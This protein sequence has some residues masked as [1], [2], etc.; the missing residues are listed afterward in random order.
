[1]AAPQ[2]ATAAPPARNEPLRSSGWGSRMA[3][4]T[5]VGSVRGTEVFVHWSVAVG[6]VLVFVVNA[7]AVDD[8]TL[9]SGEVTLAGLLAAISLYVFVLLHEFGHVEAHRCVGSGVSSVTLMMLGGATVPKDGAAVLELYGRRRGTKAWVHFAGPL[10]NIVLFLVFLGLY[11]A[12]DGWAF[13][14]MA[15]LNAVLAVYNL[16]PVSPLDGGEI[17]LDLLLCCLPL[18]VAAYATYSI[19]VVGAF[20]L[21][22]FFVVVEGGGGLFSIVIC[23][24]IAAISAYRAHL[25]WKTAGLPPEQR[26]VIVGRITGA[27]NAPGPGTFGGAAS[28]GGGGGSRV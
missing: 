26:N 5:R 8:G 7:S 15:A 27:G 13:V 1:M 22:I 23:L 25:V 24:L 9:S 20:A 19:A 17:L 6:M 2:M 11:R 12:A 3:S 28:G 18:H 14:Y 4:S 21:I 16:L 10:V